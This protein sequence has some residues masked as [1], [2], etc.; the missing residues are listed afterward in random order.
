MSDYEKD[1][2]LRETNE[3]LKRNIRFLTMLLTSTIA[4]FIIYVLTLFF[5]I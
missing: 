3:K 1:E 2:Q 4:V 5:S